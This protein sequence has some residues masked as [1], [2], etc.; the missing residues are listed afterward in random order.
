MEQLGSRS[1]TVRIGAVYSFDRLMRYSVGDRQASTEILSSF[2]RLRSART[3]RPRPMPATTPVD[4]A[5]AFEVL[6]GNAAQLR[7]ADLSGFYLEEVYLVDADLFAADLTDANLIGAAM[8]GAALNGADLTR[9]A[10]NSADL[11]GANLQAADLTDASLHGA[12]LTDANLFAVQNLGSAGLIGAS[13]ARA[14]GLD[15]LDL[16]GVNW[17]ETDLTGTDLA[18][19]NLSG[20]SLNRATLVGATLTGADLSG[21][22]LYGADLRDADLEGANLQGASLWTANLVGANLVGANLLHASLVDAQCDETTRWP[23]QLTTLP[24][25]ALDGP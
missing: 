3:S 6:D 2:I 7:R 9:A 19:T 21:V 5:A 4:I 16:P 23:A 14:N 25:C 1:I 13:M 24:D 11:T 10:L 20:A 17:R 22:D 15:E 18:D 8:A 12:D